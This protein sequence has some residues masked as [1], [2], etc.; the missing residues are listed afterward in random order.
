MVK[1]KKNER[2]KNWLNPLGLC[3]EDITLSTIEK[4][5]EN[6]LYIATDSDYSVMQSD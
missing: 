1:L 4:A 3:N 5:Q 6:E 2:K